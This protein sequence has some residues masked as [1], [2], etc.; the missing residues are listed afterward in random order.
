MIGSLDHPDLIFGTHIALVD[1]SQVWP[2]AH[3]LGK[4]A[5]KHPIVH[6]DAKTPARYPRFGNLKHSGPDP[7]AL[8]DERIVHLDPSGREVF[9]ELAVLE[10]SADLLY[11]PPY[12][13]DRVCI[14][15]FIGSPMCLAIRLIVSGKVYTSGSDPPDGR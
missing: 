15:R 4:A 12:I 2:R 8:S 14:D 5:G 7:P 1:Y 13:L 9:A 10:R 6:P 11:P 3:R